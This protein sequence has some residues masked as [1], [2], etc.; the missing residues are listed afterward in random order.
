MYAICCEMLFKFK[1]MK[2]IWPHTAS[3]VVGKRRNILIACTDNCGYSSLVLPE[4]SSGRFF[5]FNHL[6][7]IQLTYKKLDI[8][9]ECIQFDEGIFLKVHCNVESETNS[10]FCY[11]KIQQSILH[12]ERIFYPCMILENPGSPSYADIP[13][14]DTFH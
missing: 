4:N 9:N 1:C 11:L 13:N 6:I 2:K 3:Y 7:K 5:F 14:A 10:V 12:F 8:F